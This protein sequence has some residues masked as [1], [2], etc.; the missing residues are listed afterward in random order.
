MMLT[1]LAAAT[2][3]G[4]SCAA[5]CEKMKQDYAAAL[6]A[7]QPF[8]AALPSGD[9]LP[10][11]FG[12]A[13]RD[14]LLNE[15]VDRA[16]R[17]SLVKALSFTESVGVSTGQKIALTTSGEIADVGLYPDKACEQCLRVEARL[18]GS[19]TVKLPVLGSQQVPLSGGLK[20]VAPVQFGR[21]EDGQAAVKL[22]LAQA[23]KLGKSQV[24]PEVTGLPPTWW[25]VIQAPL[26]RLMVEALTRDLRP[27]TLFTF[28]GLDLGVEGL[29]VVPARIVSDAR[30]GVVFAG[31]TTNLDVPA[32]A[33]T[34]RTDLGKND[35]LAVGA[36][37]RLL[38]ALSVALLKSGSLSRTWTKEGDEAADG[39]IAVTLPTVS[40][41]AA[42]DGKQ[43]YAMTFRA[44]NVPAEGRCWWAD[45]QVLGAVEADAAGVQV[46]VEDLR[47]TESSM[48]GV[49]QAVA[50]WRTSA[51]I[52]RSSSVVTRTLT[53]EAVEFPGGKVSL[54][55]AHLV[56]D[57]DG[58]WLSGSVAVKGAGAAGGEDGDAEE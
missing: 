45:T 47:I 20:L 7:E 38:G 44:W 4:A 15:V 41:P 57:G 32:A 54:A 43:P 33:L 1:A 48:P 10:I 50:N 16:V 21:T 56:L 53:P 6:Q 31:F 40:L 2:P 3:L 19:L 35:D 23:A 52:K 34:P 5:D 37:R 8:A 42:V 29:E 49:F 22:D 28:R 12:V 13:V 25:K 51:L 27:V 30:R 18:G 24:T 11:H 17:A 26:G 39:P 36:D 9:D 55:K 58:A 14:E 46:T